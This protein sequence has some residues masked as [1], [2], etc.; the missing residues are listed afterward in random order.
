MTRPATVRHIAER[1]DVSVG[2]VSHVI[3]GT[4]RVGPELRQRVL[5]AIRELGYQPSALAQG[6]RRNRTSLLGMIIPDVTNPFFPEVV[7]GAED[8]AFKN[9]YRVVL[10]NADND[11]SKEAAYL[12]DLRSFRVAGML[13]IPAVDSDA[14]R[15]LVEDA[16]GAP[17][18]VF[19]DRS[20]E[21]WAGDL[22]L[23]ANELGAYNATKHLI[24]AG[25]RQ[26]AVITGPAHVSNASERLNGFLRSCGEAGL[27]VAPE[28]IHYGAF[29]TRSGFEAATR[30]FQLASRPTGI[31][32]CNDLIALG[33][34]HAGH[35]QGLRCPDDF[36]LIGFDSLDF[37][38]YTSPPLTSV[39]Q[40]GYQLGAVAAGLLVDRINGLAESPKRI[41]LD[42]ELRLRGSVLAVSALGEVPR[43]KRLRSFAVQALPAG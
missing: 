28:F 31:F 8:V 7:R 4:A 14:A 16:P 17:P 37:C 39:Y 27:P 18:V 38:E 24:E 3:N 29:D 1:A 20:P 10:C 9:Q 43:P 15:K 42:A 6:L 32:A 22:V 33:V 23:V 11:P 25:H 13:I 30:L 34:L 41:L 36:S 19:L 12:M 35:E 2:T 5:D 26:L 40:P 21:A